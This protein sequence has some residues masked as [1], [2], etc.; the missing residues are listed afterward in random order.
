[1][2]F[3]DY[4]SLFRIVDLRYPTNLVIVILSTLAGGAQFIIR[5]YQSK[6][7]TDSIVA[8]IP[9]GITVFLTWAIGR[10][11]DPEHELAAFAGLILVVPGYWLLGSPNLLA[12][13]SMLM[14][15]RLIN[16]TTGGTPKMLDSLAL[17]G[18]GGWLTFR[19]DWIYGL[20]IAAG[21]LLDSR[22]PTPK[23]QN[24]IF[25]GIM[26]LLTVLI[27]SISG[28]DLPQINPSIPELF[29]V[30]VVVLLFI[31][32]IK[33]SRYI[34]VFCD[35]PGETINPLRLQ[36]SQ[37]FAISTVSFV[38]ILKG[39]IGF[40]ELLPIWSS[41]VAVSTVFLVISFLR[42]VRQKAEQT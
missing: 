32:L 4:S 23:N 42:Y 34:D 26:A 5:L 35:L 10:E 11:I 24:L 33:Q 39:K 15:L 41:I 8:A 3:S 25:S 38:W 36:V 30:A 1:M 40:I 21:F 28:T 18:F 20:L 19:G 27:A 13:I 12:V 14:V 22:L 16:R 37:I 17:T 9:I 6:D 29:F 31:P 7:L 2:N